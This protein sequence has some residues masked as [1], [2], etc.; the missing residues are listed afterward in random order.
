MSVV[1]NMGRSGARV[2]LALAAAGGSLAWDCQGQ[3]SVRMSLAGAQAAEARRQAAETVNY[4]NVKVGPSAWRFSA[5]TEL[6][7]N[8]NLRGEAVNQQAD[9]IWRPE[10]EAEMRLAVSEVNG[11]SLRVGGGYAFY[12]Q[13]GEY[14]RP[15]IRPGS[16]VSMDVYAGDFW[17]NAHDRFAIVEEGYLDPTVTGIGNYERLDN[18]A[19]VAATWDLNRVVA[20]VGYDHMTYGSLSGGVGERDGESEVLAGSAGYVWQAGMRAGLE[21]GGGLMHYGAAG[22]GRQFRDGREWSAGGFWEG[23]LTEHI[24]GRAGGGY[25]VFRPESGVAAELGQEFSGVY[26]EVG[27]AHRVNERVEYGLSGGRR[28]NFGYFGG[29]LDQYFCRWE[30]SWRILRKTAITTTFSWQHGAQVGAGAETFEWFGPG[31]SASRPL[32]SKLI[33]SLGY[34]YYWRGSNLP[35]RDYAAN[36]ATGRLTYRF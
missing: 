16:E 8:D 12:V 27:V 14:D 13:H 18:A 17:I 2:L 25:T 6:Q 19:G 32:T 9:V 36:L 26:G 21:V 28:L 11:L 4:Y 1:L 24:Q 35:G 33:G 29:L 7:V 31:V 30:G 20:R 5:G 34:Q 3:E 15:F 23:Q 22:G 10:V